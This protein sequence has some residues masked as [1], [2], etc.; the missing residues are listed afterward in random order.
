MWGL[1]LITETHQ[2]ILYVKYSVYTLD[3]IIIIKKA[4]RPYGSSSPDLALKKSFHKVDLNSALGALL[5]SH[6]QIHITEN[7]NCIMKCVCVLTFLLTA[8][9]NRQKKRL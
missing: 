3:L 8:V 2:S 4:L 6:I 5:N 1:M 7:Q 9:L